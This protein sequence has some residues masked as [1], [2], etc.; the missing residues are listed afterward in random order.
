M[1]SDQDKE[2]MVIKSCNISFSSSLLVNVV[3]QDP[4]FPQ[5]DA[6]GRR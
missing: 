1:G 6:H 4:T 2:S 5:A 3:L